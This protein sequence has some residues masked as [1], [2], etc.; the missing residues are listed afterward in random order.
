[1]A[2][3][4]LGAK[5]AHRRLVAEPMVRQIAMQNGGGRVR[6]HKRECEREFTFV[7]TRPETA[8]FLRADLWRTRCTPPNRPM[9]TNHQKSPA[10]VAAWAALAIFTVSCGGG[11]SP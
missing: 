5:P 3:S 9:H 11:S 6:N 2:G 7:G 10:M 1:M 8:H 4:R